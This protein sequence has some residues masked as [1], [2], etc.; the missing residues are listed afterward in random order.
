MQILP[1]ASLEGIPIVT[2]QG[3]R[4]PIPGQPG[5]DEGVGAVQGCGFRDRTT[6]QPPTFTI[7]HGKQISHTLRW[8]KWTN[9]IHM[10][11]SEA[12]VWHFKF[13]GFW[14]KSPL[15]FDAL[16]RVTRLDIIR[17]E[18][19]HFREEETRTGSSVSLCLTSV[20]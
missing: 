15:T 19:L 1:E 6:F 20:I 17:D 5:P 16:T 2:G 12:P 14:Y 8:G 7:N 13:S 18:F 3:L 11:V 4:G 9:H 10:N